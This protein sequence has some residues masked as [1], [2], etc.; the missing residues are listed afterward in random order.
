MQF[1][2]VKTDFA[3][4]KVFGSPHS[5]DLLISFLNALLDVGDY[6]IVDL[7]IVDPY[8]IPLI[9]GMKDTFVDVKA[10]LSN[11]SQV[12]IEMQVL[13]VEMEKRVLYHAAKAYSMQLQRGQPY[14]LLNPVIAL[15]ITDF[16]M[17]PEEELKSFIITYFKLLETRKFIEYSN[18]IEL[19]F[20]ELPKFQKTEAELTTLTDK[21]VYF[22][23]HAGSL[24][25]VPPPLAC[26]SEIVQAFQIANEAGLTKEELE[27]QDKKLRW[28][29]TQRLLQEQA[30]QVEAIERRLQQAQQEVQQA[31]QEVQQAQQ[32][33]QQAKQET[34]QARLEAQQTARKIAQQLFK[35]GAELAFIQQV[36]GLQWIELEAF[37]SLPAESNKS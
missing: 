9:E 37:H 22:V 18:D 17:F 28:L 6:P 1:L 23:K 34:Q 14:T 10:V 4:K 36:T 30:G 16:I 13:S 15:T 7:T 2:D 29:A 5:K 33:V 32:E 12:I 26:E 20:V 25:M 8:Q 35:T 21:W 11:G 24:E 31:Q 3:F 27:V 19:V